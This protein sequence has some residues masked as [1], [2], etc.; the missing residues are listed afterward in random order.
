[1]FESKLNTS[2]CLLLPITTVSTPVGDTLLADKVYKSYV[3]VIEAG[4]VSRLAVRNP[5]LQC[6]LRDGL[7]IHISHQTRLFPND[8]GF[9]YPGESFYSVVR[10][11]KPN[12][13]AYYTRYSGEPTCKS[14]LF[15]ILAY[16]I[17][18]LEIKKELTEVPVVSRCSDVF[19]DGLTSLPPYR[20]VEFSID[21]VLGYG[22]NL[23]STLRKASSEPK[24]LII[25]TKGI[26]RTICSRNMFHST[27][28]I[29][30]ACTGSF[31]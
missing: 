5:R 13:L 18:G 28:Y 31:C 12:L 23:K 15:R 19:L 17:R 6:D 9:S 29:T 24:E 4:T 14:R 22:T 30:L 27:E 21:V 8:S 20:E 1:M 7:V 11:K 25:R 26:K 3:V 10:S 16:V 2:P